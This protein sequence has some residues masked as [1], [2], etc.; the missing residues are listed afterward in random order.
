MAP[1]I[2]DRP[3][4]AG[5]T[6]PTT[7]IR[8]P[9]AVLGRL[10]HHGCPIRSQERSDRRRMAPSSPPA[11]RGVTSPAIR[12]MRLDDAVEAADLLRR[13]DFGERLDFFRWALA[14]P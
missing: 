2:S 10:G 4:A 13:H 8:S 5:Q 6:P 12:A 9:S 1:M 7:M 3:A 11:D 14:Q